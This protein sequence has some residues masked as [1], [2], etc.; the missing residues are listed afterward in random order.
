MQEQL[1]M[2]RDLNFGGKLRKNEKD[3]LRLKSSREMYCRHCLKG[4]TGR[5][6]LSVCKRPQLVYQEF[7]KD[8]GSLRTHIFRLLLLL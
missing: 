2:N 8:Y 3:N 5:V 4:E 1:Y 6:T 7:S